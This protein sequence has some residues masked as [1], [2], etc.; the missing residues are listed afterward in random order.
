MQGLREKGVDV[1]F[2]KVVQGTPMAFI[3]D[4]AGNLIELIQFPELW[5]PSTSDSKENRI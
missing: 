5:N 1:V 3:R 4:N 2:E